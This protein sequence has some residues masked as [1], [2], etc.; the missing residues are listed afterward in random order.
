MVVVRVKWCVEGLN[1]AGRLTSKTTSRERLGSLARWTTEGVGWKNPPAKPRSYPYSPLAP[2]IAR[3]VSYTLYSV[4]STR[5]IK[6][7][8]FFYLFLD[9]VVARSGFVFWWVT[10]FCNILSRRC[11]KVNWAIS[12]FRRVD[13]LKNECRDVFH[14]SVHRWR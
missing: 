3:S 13:K 9:I 12:S 7:T 2:P 6:S 4:P 11:N 10:S 14:E 5:Q 8:G 1:T